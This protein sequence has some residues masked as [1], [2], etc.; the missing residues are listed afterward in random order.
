[1]IQKILLVL[2]LSGSAYAGDVIGNGGDVIT[3]RTAEGQIQSI[4]PLD[5]YEGREVHSLTLD[6]G[7]PTAT[8]QEKFQIFYDRLNRLSHKRAER[9]RL[10]FETFFDNANLKPDIELADVPDSEHLYLPTHCK[11]EQIAIQMPPNS[12]EE[13]RYLISKDLWDQ[14][15]NDGKIGVI[16]HEIIYREAIEHGHSN[17]VFVRYLN[18][19]V[20]SAAFAQVS[21]ADFD[22]KLGANKFFTPF[23]YPNIFLD[24]RLGDKYEDG[25]FSRGS[26]REDIESSFMLEGRKIVITDTVYFDQNGNIVSFHTK[27]PIQFQVADQ[28]MTSNPYNAVFIFPSGKLKQID[29][30][31]RELTVPYNGA[32]TTIKAP[33]EFNEN[34]TFAALNLKKSTVIQYHDTPYIV[35]RLELFPNSTIR[36]FQSYDSFDWTIQGVRTIV[37]KNISFHEN[38]TVAA[39]TLA[40][41]CHLNLWGSPIVVKDRLFLDSQ[42]RILAGTMVGE[43]QAMI[44][45]TLTRIRPRQPFEYEMANVNFMLHPEGHVGAANL[46]QPIDIQVGDTNIGFSADTKISFYPNGGVQDG[47][48]RSPHTFLIQ[49][50]SVTLFHEV[51]DWGIQFYQNGKV[52]TAILMEE[53]ELMSNFGLRTFRYGTYLTFDPNQVVTFSQLASLRQRR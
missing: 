1:M 22:E 20:S 13:K 4:E 17:S 14:M 36:G 34:G 18:A 24:P 33:F 30:K 38:G 31:E 50:K 10:D 26:L 25:S 19:W 16:L 6:L 46:G 45:G 40:E 37:D 35:S 42:E 5:H 32:E 28:N 48:M 49:G 51:R 52:K 7:G 12:S 43:S 29:P 47:M 53:A 27:N 3:C 44:Q 15:N 2:V 11:I 23:L 21:Q 39:V 9:Y 8:L 41:P